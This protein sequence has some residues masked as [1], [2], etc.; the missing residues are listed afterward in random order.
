[1]KTSFDQVLR[2]TLGS[3][4]NDWVED[5]ARPHREKYAL[6]NLMK[7]GNAAT[8]ALRKG[9][10]HESAKVRVG[11]CRALDHFMDEDAVPE[12][13]ENLEHP[14]P[15]VRAWALHALACD[16]CKEGTCRPGED[17]VI[18]LAIRLAK[19]DP[20]RGVR[21][22]A[23]DMLGPSVHRNRDVAALMHYIVANEPDTTI[24]KVAGWWVP[25]GSRFEKT[26]IRGT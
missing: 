12:L 25:G 18:P 20:H 2:S 7:L 8:P 19:E 21:K 5:L 17:A 3:N 14:D 11:C 15:E 23:V 1:V 24:R 9:L 4:P 10:Q 13:I 16:R 26:K 22:M 6:R